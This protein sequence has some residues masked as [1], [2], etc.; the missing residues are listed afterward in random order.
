MRS[1]AVWKLNRLRAMSL[2]E[3]ALRSARALDSGLDR[4]FPA[5]RKVPE[6]STAPR[7]GALLVRTDAP[8][9]DAGPYIAAARRIVTGRWPIFALDQADV[10]WPPRW[11]RDP[12]SGIEAPLIYGPGL[13]YRSEKLVGNIKYLWEPNRHLELVSLAQ[14]WFLTRARSHADAAGQLL[15]SWLDACPYPLGPNWTS[16]LELAIRLANW[17]VAW[18]LLGGDDS[19]LFEGADGGTLRADWLRSVYRHCSFIA[20]HLS[21]HSSANNHLL[22]EYTGLYLAALRW[23]CWPISEQWLRTARHG[24]ETEA[25]K[26][27]AP[28]G[29]N[30]EQALY[31]GHEVADMM[32]L[33]GLASRRA[34]DRG[35]SDAYW[36]RL[37]AMLGFLAATMSVD[38]RVPMI[39][40]ADD[41]LVVRF[42]PTPTFCPYRSLLA[43]GAVLFERPEFKRKAGTF[44]GKSRWLLGDQGKRSF[45]SLPPA[46]DNEKPRAFEHGGY[47]VMGAGLG[48]RD[49]VRLVADAGPL[50]YLSIAAH[51]HADALSFV[52]SVAGREILIDPGTFSYHTDRRR[53]AYFRGTSAHN[54][55]RIDGQDQSVSGGNFLWL[56]KA[57]TQVQ[58]WSSSDE[59]DILAARHDG[60]RRLADPVVHS[61]RLRLDKRRMAVHVEDR[62]DCRGTHDVEL[63]WHFAEDCKVRPVESGCVARSGPAAVSLATQAQGQFE[64]PALQLFVGDDEGPLGWV[65]RRFDRQVPAPTLCWAAR[66]HGSVV[67]STVIDLNLEYVDLEYP[68]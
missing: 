57:N 17:T 61:R 33:A 16:S 30:R 7:A 48:R 60:Y 38:G 13:D 21:M 6:P 66:V 20:G 42:D 47:Y 8:G 52:L 9:I 45:E 29:V 28:D 31:Y 25:L 11:N 53:R 50:G 12:R 63:H 46:R 65:S 36:H 27:N 32:L 44:D 2:A 49:E 18:E 55:V 19:P 35:F 39:G 51:G 58:H 24:L 56:H 3:V 62:I 15:R 68:E 59:E 43:T 40:D 23:P 37:E 4:W 67:L 41:A 34:Q 26:Q 54:T 64:P 5:A 22:G 10:G 14:A 1:S